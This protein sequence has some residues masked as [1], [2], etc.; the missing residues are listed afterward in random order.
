MRLQ[1]LMLLVCGLLAVG[2]SHAADEP[3]AAKINQIRLYIPTP[4][5]EERIGNDVKPLANY[6]KAL[7]K[8]TAEFMAKEKQPKAKGVLIAVGIKSKTKTRIWCEAVDGDVPDGLL[9]KLEKELAKVEAVD[10]KKAPIAFAIE[11]NLFGQ[12][13]EKFPEF[14]KVWFESRDK[15]KPT[16]VVPPDDLF[17]SIWPD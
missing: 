12:K 2:S 16:K 10:P 17:K 6:I 13:A 3:K 14:P 8:G 9:H 4:M 11:I 5:L 7:E 15:D 1:H